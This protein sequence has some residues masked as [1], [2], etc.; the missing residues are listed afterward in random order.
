M[1]GFYNEFVKKKRM[2]K[3]YYVCIVVC[4]MLNIAKAQTQ[5]ETTLSSSTRVS[6]EGEGALYFA[7]TRD[8]NFRFSQR[9]S[10][11]GD[12][13]DV[14]NGFAFVTWYKGSI[15]NGRNLM[16]SRKNLNVPN[17]E[18]VTIEFPHKHI[19]Q[20]GELLRGTGIR[21]DSHNTAAIGVSTIDNTI[22]ILL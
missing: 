14:V 11:H 20:G 4:L 10:P 7:G 13:V 15:A 6:E 12:C 21:G 3:Y 19:G 17:A 22:H 5:L 8:V 16:L 9:I 2:K 18:W 1:L